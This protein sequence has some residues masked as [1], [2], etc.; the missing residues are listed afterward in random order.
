M[1]ITNPEDIKKLKDDPYTYEDLI[2]MPDGEII[3]ANYGHV[4]ALVRIFGVPRDLLYVMIDERDNPQF[5]LL[6][7]TGCMSVSK[8]A[9]FGMNRNKVQKEVHEEL[10]RNHIVSNNYYDITEER[11]IA[12]Q[13]YGGNNEH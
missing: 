4:N 11:E 1:R 2:I 6:E 12:K 5:W 10:V 7:K 3:N 9:A 13:F 8:R